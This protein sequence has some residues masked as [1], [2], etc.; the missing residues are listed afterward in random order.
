MLLRGWVKGKVLACALLGAHPRTLSPRVRFVE[1]GESSLQVEILCYS[2]TGLW[3]GWHAIREDIYLRTMEIVKESGSSFAFPSQTTYF[4]RD[5]GMDEARHQA[6][7]QQVAAW[8]AACELPF[9][10]MTAGEM[11]ALAGTLDFPPK[12]S[13]VHESK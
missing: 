5:E 7:E 6:A 12:G 1:F 10:D 13:V 3:A 8:R 11:E 2:D 9:P 4:A